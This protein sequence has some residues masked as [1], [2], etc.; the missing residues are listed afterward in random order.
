MYSD[1]RLFINNLLQEKGDDTR[2]D[3]DLSL[4]KTEQ[5]PMDKTRNVEF[6]MQVRYDFNI[7]KKKY[8]LL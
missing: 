3:S 7:I 4:V 8:L 5:N 6:V 1:S 2:L